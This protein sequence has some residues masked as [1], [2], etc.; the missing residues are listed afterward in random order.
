M[1]IH[2]E[3]SRIA[4]QHPRA[5]IVAACIGA[6]SLIGILLDQVFK[7]VGKRDPKARLPPGPT[8]IWLF[9]SLST[10]AKH[11]DEGLTEYVQTKSL[12][13]EERY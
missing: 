9:G 3:I 10:L 4:L 12:P 7:P 8:G 5:A 13:P 11:R 1:A 2:N 6:I